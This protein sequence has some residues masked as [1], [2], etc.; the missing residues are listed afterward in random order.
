MLQPETWIGKPLPIAEYIDADLSSGDWTILLHRHDCPE[1][2]E[3][4]P[5]YED[6]A[7]QRNIAIVEMP[8]YNSEL[9]ADGPALHARLPDDREWFVQTPVEIQLDDGIVVN[10]STE[11]P[12]ITLD[13]KM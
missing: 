1:F 2:Q 13:G 10:A 11:L 7:Y 8:P 5:R 4:V 12:V 3:A 9:V 6:L